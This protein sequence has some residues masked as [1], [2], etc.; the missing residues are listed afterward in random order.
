VAG[1]GQRWPEL[2]EYMCYLSAGSVMF[3]P[4]IAG[5]WQ[6]LPVRGPCLTLQRTGIPASLEYQGRV[7]GLGLFG[8]VFWI[9]IYLEL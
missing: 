9:L 5:N 8:A 3:Y 2:T 4:A 6:M 1:W 7:A